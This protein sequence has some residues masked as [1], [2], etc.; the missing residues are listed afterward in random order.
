MKSLY[1]TLVLLAISVLSLKAQDNEKKGF[2]KKYPFVNMTEFGVLMGRTKFP[3]GYSRYDVLGKPAPDAITYYNVQNR[4]N[5]SIMT[6]NGIYLNPKTA[7]GVTTGIDW[8][9]T[10]VLMPIMAG[11]RR[12]I[13]QKKEGGSAIFVNLDGG[14]ATNWLNEDSGITKTDGGFVLNPSIGY[15]LPMRSG[16]A[17]L[18]NFGYRMQKYKLTEDR[19]QEEW[20]FKSV[21]TRNL[22]RMSLRVGL[23]F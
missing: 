15:R 20:S 8:Y 6:F 16:S 9:N 19:S 5:V 1:K 10:T 4:V 11:V 12:Q 7:V 3:T 14:Y 2:F 23:E 22:N 21:E 13:A 18:V 17:W